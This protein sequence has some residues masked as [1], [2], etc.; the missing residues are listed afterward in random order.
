MIRSFL[1]EYGMLF[2]V[3]IFM[4][5]TLGT[6]LNP[7]D[8]HT[9]TGHDETQAS[10][11]LEFS[12]NLK[13]GNI[14]PRIAPN[15]SFGMGYPIF[16]YYAPTAYWITS[17]LHLSGFSVPSALELSYLLALFMGLSGMYLFLR[18]FF[19]KAISLAGS[20]L[21]VTSPYIAVE[22]FVRANLAEMWFFALLP[23]SLYL[24]LTVT[25][26]R[27]FVTVIFTSLLLTSHN[28]LSLI[29]IPLLIIVPL[30]Q[31]KYLAMGAIITSLLLSSY[32]FIPAYG[33]LSL[34]RAT[35]IA[36]STQ[37]KDHFLCPSQWW[38][39][40]WGFGGSAK[41]CIDDGISFMLGKFLILL[42]CIGFVLTIRNLIVKN[43]V[44]K[45]YHLSN[46]FALLFFTSLFMTTSYSQAFWQ[47]LPFLSVV[48]FPWRFL[49]LSV[50]AM[51]IL[52]AFS[53]TFLPRKLQAL[54][55][56]ILLL[57][58]LFMNQKFFVGGTMIP[59][60]E[61]MNLYGSSQYVREKS[62][63]K[64][65][66]YVLSTVDYDLWRSLETKPGRIS[67][68]IVTT[69]KGQE[70]IPLINKPFEKLF[71]AKSDP[72][73]PVNIHWG[74]WWSMKRNNI[75]Y[76]PKA[77]DP[78][79]RPLIDVSSAEFETISISYHQTSRELLANA[80]SILTGILITVYSFHHIIW[81]QKKKT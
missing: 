29:S 6:H 26:K 22:I 28:V 46:I 39:S 65:A 68:S 64:V 45:T 58:V 70:V 30:S 34:V 67:E 18:R 56:F 11:I 15:M 61:Y 52:S 49:L 59:N 27:M 44:D 60:N 9:F 54:C 50:F 63:F 72:N 81:R 19:S 38:Y 21:Y 36:Q 40:P 4:A 16:N 80:I 12:L 1:K 77:L 41:G 71:L 5:F 32:F 23:L 37:F 31:K 42:S 51:S 17:L 25:R 69:E 33:E 3:G 14:P 53:L 47:F 79:G 55:A 24:L 57:T 75:M 20:V 43:I 35:E 2:V 66:E 78:L 13:E 74:P 7:F 73:I 76:E 48:Q 8:S 10:R 62:A